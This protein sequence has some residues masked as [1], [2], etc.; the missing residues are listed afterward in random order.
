MNKKTSI[1]AAGA[2]LLS[3]AVSHAVTIATTYT[4]SHDSEAEGGAA[5]HAAANHLTYLTDGVITTDWTHHS[6][7]VG[8]VTPGSW[9]LD[10]NADD[11]AVPTIT[12]LFP[13][14]PLLET[15]SIS[16]L[17]DDAL[18]IGSPDSYDIIIGGILKTFANST[19]LTDASQTE[20][21]DL[22]TQFSVAELT[23]QSGMIVTVIADNITEGNNNEPWVG[24]SEYSV[25]AT[26]VP[27]PSLAALFALGGLALILR[28]RK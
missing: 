8:G 5:L 10:N 26:A 16:Y 1:L 13:T 15:F 21:I 23:N 28:R 19:D 11:L 20:V 17:T 12:I 18:G 22:S 7:A 6:T 2:S 14:Q 3:C 24:L 9:H 4:L 25:T 27:E